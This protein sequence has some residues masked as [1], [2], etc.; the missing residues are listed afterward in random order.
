[1]EKIEN[2]KIENIKDENTRQVLKEEKLKIPVRVWI[3]SLGL[4]FVAVVFTL[5]RPHPIF[6]VVTL[7]ITFSQV[8]F[9]L[10]YYQTGYRLTQHGLEILGKS[11]VVLN[12]PYTDMLEVKEG[13]F[14]QLINDPEVKQIDGAK[15]IEAYP[16]LGG[17]KLLTLIMYKQ[18]EQTKAL[19]FQPS[20]TLRMFI[21]DRIREQ[22]S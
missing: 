1:M 22:V 17:A 9:L 14:R 21:E 19:F 20:L 2:M 16:K 11:K 4:I 10:N 8:K 3:N 18:G 7:L 12:I 13:N 15:D 6:Y 5:G